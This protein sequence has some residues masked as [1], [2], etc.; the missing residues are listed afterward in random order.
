MSVEGLEYG[1]IQSRRKSTE[2]KVVRWSLLV[3][4]LVMTLAATAAELVLAQMTHCITF[5]CLVHQ[6]IYNSLTLTVSLV[7]RSKGSNPSLS[8]TFG[9]RRMEVVGAVAALVFLFSLCFATFIE[10]WQTVLHIGHLDTMH[11]PDWIMMALGGQVLVWAGTY[12]AIGG[13]SHHQYRAVRDIQTQ[14]ANITRDLMGVMFTFTVCSVIHFQVIT[15]EYETYIDPLA[16]M[17]YIVTLIWS[18][19]P[20]TRDSC[21]ILLQTIPGNV[22]VHTLKKFILQKFPGILSLHE[23]HI[24]T[25][26]PREMV[27]TAHVTYK[28]KEV[29]REIHTQVSNFFTSQG[30][31]MLTLQPEFPQEENLTRQDSPTCTLACKGSKCTEMACCN[32]DTGNPNEEC[33]GHQEGQHREGGEEQ[34]A[35]ESTTF[36]D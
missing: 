36:L 8:N 12:L 34:E 21:L 5:L 10:A 31:S 29:Y 32:G 20:L 26:T 22:E 3:T 15:E 35:M 2:E 19:I 28:N 13:Y 33:C 18:C 11:H 4:V 9:W 30:F 27:L 25:L 24:W 23:V 6:N 7:S 17:I 16:S 14:V 1:L